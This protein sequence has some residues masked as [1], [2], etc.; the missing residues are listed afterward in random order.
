MVVTGR[1]D[2][3]CVHAA[4]KIIA[5]KEGIIAPPK[6]VARLGHMAQDQKRSEA[7]LCHN[8]C[9]LFL[10]K[11]NQNQHTT[12]GTSTEQ[13][14]RRR[15]R[16]G[17][18]GA[19]CFTSSE[20]TLPSRIAA[21]MTSSSRTENPCRKTRSHNRKTETSLPKSCLPRQPVPLDDPAL[22]WCSAASPFTDNDFPLAVPAEANEKSSPSSFTRQDVLDR[23]AAMQDQESSKPYIVRDY[24]SITSIAEDDDNDESSE[25]EDS[26]GKE[27]GHKQHRMTEDDSSSASIPNRQPDSKPATAKSSKK[28]RSSFSQPQ[29]TDA[30]CREKMVVWALQVVDYCQ[31]NRQTAELS[32]RM[33]DRLLSLAVIDH[34]DCPDQHRQLAQSCLQNRKIYQLAAMTCL[35]TSIKLHETQVMSPDIVASLSRGMSTAN[36]VVE[37]ESRILAALGYHLCG[38][39]GVDVVDH[40]VQLLPSSTPS[41]VKRV[42]I[43]RSR[44]AIHQSLLDYDLSRTVSPT[45]LGYAALVHTLDGLDEWTRTQYI[46]GDDIVTDIT[47]ALF[48]EDGTI[49]EDLIVW[50]MHRIKDFVGG[51]D[52]TAKNKSRTPPTSTSSSST[53][54]KKSSTPG[55]SLSSSSCGK[56]RE[57]IDGTSP[58]TVVNQPAAAVEVTP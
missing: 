36:Q 19:T 27:N 40:L 48:A 20:S 50:S 52:D 47:L 45:L 34:N 37:M 24:L 22:I 25:D 56:R 23:L 13:I 39:T 29:P 58:R 30:I 49:D 41:H 17:S 4:R 42:V 51:G 14:N 15:P 53:N 18:G 16:G 5:Q 31:L 3:D 44:Y 7:K 35:Y 26:S 1:D 57:S 54:T 8:Y 6:D 21:R 11:S 9:E 46:D 28:K 38:P 10:S 12:M 32:I 43:E 33:L 55:P 2:R